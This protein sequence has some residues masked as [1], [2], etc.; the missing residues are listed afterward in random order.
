MSNGV[1][2]GIDVA[3]KKKGFAVAA[4][5]IASESWLNLEPVQTVDEVVDLIDRLRD[6]RQIAIDCPPTAVV[7]SECTRGCERELHKAR[8]S[9]QWTPREANGGKASGWM[10]NGQEL[11]SA[12]KSR[13]GGLIIETFPT[14]ACDQL[15]GCELRIPLQYFAH[16]KT[17]MHYK[18]LIDA[19]LCAW[20]AK[21][22]LDGKSA[23]VGAD[24][25]GGK[26]YF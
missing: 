25:D 12:L 13:Y 26:I 21:K 9:V 8:Y 17:R 15:Q 22:H 1:V 5:D 20:V 7:T 19:A 16:K 11:W 6:V 4:L 3:G 2:V 10:L 14:A 24:D 23:S 18:D